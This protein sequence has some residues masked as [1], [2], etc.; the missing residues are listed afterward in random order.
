M[1]TDLFLLDNLIIFHCTYYL[2][3][4]VLC[5][6][7][8]HHTSFNTAMY[9]NSYRKLHGENVL[10]D[11]PL[12]VPYQPCDPQVINLSVLYAYVCM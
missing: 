8:V 3:D 4:S 5:E 2:F 12:R 11:V 10:G 6:T 7:E 1:C 9:R